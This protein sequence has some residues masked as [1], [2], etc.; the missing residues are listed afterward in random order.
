MLFS[1]ILIANVLAVSFSLC[2]A[3]ETVAA[4]ESMI[5]P[6]PAPE[7][8]KRNIQ[9]RD[10]YG[11]RS[12]FIGYYTEGSDCKFYPHFKFKYAADPVI[13]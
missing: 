6:A 13:T 1:Q 4:P 5:T 9:K 12:D 3:D 8:V 2:A 7:L 10:P 11:S